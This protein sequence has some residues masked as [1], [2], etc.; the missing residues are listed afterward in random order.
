MFF[1][2]FISVSFNM[3]FG[4]E[5]YGINIFGVLMMKIFFFSFMFFGL[6]EF[7]LGR[8]LIGV[9]NFFVMLGCVFVLVVL[10]KCRLWFLSLF[11]RVDLFV[12]GI[13]II[14]I[15]SLVR[16]FIFCV[17]FFILFSNG[18][19][20]VLWGFIFKKMMFFILFIF[21]GLWK[22]F[23]IWMICFGGCVF[24][25]GCLWEVICVGGVRFCLV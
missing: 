10:F 1:I 16:E 20:D 4:L 3:V 15:F 9:F 2:Y 21:G 18:C 14:I 22:V 25:I 6:F 5:M 23:K 7:F 17:I 12:F 13:F 8:I 19:K 11:S 24:G